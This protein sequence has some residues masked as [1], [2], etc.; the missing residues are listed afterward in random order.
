MLSKRMYIGP[1]KGPIRLYLS[2][3]TMITDNMEAPTRSWADP[4]ADPP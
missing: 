3:G 4:K 2:Y 1:Y